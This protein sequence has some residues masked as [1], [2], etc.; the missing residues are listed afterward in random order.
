MIKG[1]FMQLLGSIIYST[2]AFYSFEGMVYLANGLRFLVLP[3]LSSK[4][5]WKLKEMVKAH[6]LLDLLLVR[7]VARNV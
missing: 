4:K 1:Y 2:S 7:I 6:I 5:H 3:E